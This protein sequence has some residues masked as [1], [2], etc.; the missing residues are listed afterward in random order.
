MNKNECNC[1]SIYLADQCLLSVGA[2]RS[3]EACDITAALS[4]VPVF[5]LLVLPG[6]VA[7]YVSQELLSQMFG[8]V[9]GL[10]QDI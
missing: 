2:D 3:N 7:P 5:L 1:T 9:C 10:V 6:D 8:D 4:P